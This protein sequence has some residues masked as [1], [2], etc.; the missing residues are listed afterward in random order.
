M[1]LLNAEWWERCRRQR[2]WAENT[3]EWNEDAGKP[4]SLIE[5]T[6]QASGCRRLV[7]FWLRSC[8][9][10][11]SVPDRDEFGKQTVFIS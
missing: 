6:N 8:S 5:E 9:N 1:Y 11:T 2:S 3:L 10:L 7:R 4:W